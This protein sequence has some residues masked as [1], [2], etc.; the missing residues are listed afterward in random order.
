MSKISVGV[1]STIAKPLPA[2]DQSNLTR[3]GRPVKLP[4]VELMY[5]GL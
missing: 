4:Q 5:M 3:N 1:G 2:I